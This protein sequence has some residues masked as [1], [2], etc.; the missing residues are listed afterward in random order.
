MKTIRALLLFSALFSVMLL[1]SRPAL[2]IG[3]GQVSSAIIL[4]FGAVFALTHGYY[5]GPMNSF[6]DTNVYDVD[7]YFLYFW[8]N[9]GSG[10]PPVLY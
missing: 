4:G 10:L 6:P 9:N 2:A 7:H 1:T 8:I 5:P 3:T